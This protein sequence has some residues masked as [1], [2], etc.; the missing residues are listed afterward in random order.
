MAEEES[1]VHSLTVVLSGVN[2][3]SLRCCAVS[4]GERTRK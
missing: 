3:S 2:K 1:S 4:A